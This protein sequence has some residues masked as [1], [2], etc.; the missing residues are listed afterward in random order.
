MSGMMGY[1][2]EKTYVC[3][4]SNCHKEVASV[5]GWKVALRD[6][7]INCPVEPK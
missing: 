2:R 7:P 1:R 5:G 6:A 3:F 4:R